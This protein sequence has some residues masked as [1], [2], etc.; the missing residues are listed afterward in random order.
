MLPLSILPDIPKRPLVE[1]TSDVA[2]IPK[3]FR[4]DPLRAEEMGLF[5]SESLDKRRAN[6]LRRRIKD[7]LLESAEQ[8]FFFQGILYGIR[9]L[10]PLYPRHPRSLAALLQSVRASY[11]QSAR[12]GGVTPDPTLLAK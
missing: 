1:K 11:L 7:D 8:G 4:P 6:H 2:G 3:A 12:S 5:Y 9:L 10:V